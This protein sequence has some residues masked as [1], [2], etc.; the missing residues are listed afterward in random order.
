MN[1]YLGKPIS[2][3]SLADAI[4]RWL[5]EGALARTAPRS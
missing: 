1:D 3:R 4:G 5:G 2:A